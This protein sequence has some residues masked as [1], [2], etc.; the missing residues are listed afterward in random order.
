MA[1]LDPVADLERRLDRGVGQT[2]RAMRSA[3]RT[4]WREHELA[5]HPATVGKR[6]ALALI[7]KRRALYKHA[8]T[9]VLE[10]LADQ[11]R[12]A[13]LV[14]F[15]R[16][17][18]DG[19]L[20]GDHPVEREVV[21]RFGTLV[22]ATMLERELGRMEVARSLATWRHA[23]TIW[24]RRA[25]CLAFVRVAPRADAEL[26]ST[27]LAVCGTVVWSHERHDQTAVATLLRELA[28]A[29]PARV[30]A[31]FVRHARF[32]PRPCARTCVAK[33]PEHK[34]KELLAHHKR[35]TTI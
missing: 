23:V 33:L 15:A 30:E 21:D 26:A 35:A 9:F 25:A 32:M 6:I 13:D 31:F 16:L 17:F 2:W 29:E 12:C 1:A 19:H 22:L 4:W 27:I 3:I 5:D 34:R 24:Q 28:R 8:G 7:E 18:D 10:L 14:A 11:L 20:C